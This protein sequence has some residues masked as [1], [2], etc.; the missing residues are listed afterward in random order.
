MKV[1]LPTCDKYDHLIPGFAWLFNKYWSA[2]QQVIVCGYREP[3]GLPPNFSFKSLGETET[4]PW[5]DAIRPIIAAE[6]DPYL[7]LFLDDYWLYAPIWHTV[8][9][10]LCAM[11]QSGEIQKADLSNNT[12]GLGADAYKGKTTYWVS[13]QEATYRSSLQPAIWSTKYLLK[14]LKPGRTIWQFELAG[15]GEACNDK[16]KIVQHDS[17]IFRY[18]NIYFKGGITAWQVDKLAFTDLQQ[19]WDANICRD[20]LLHANYI[21]NKE[22]GK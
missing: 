5:T 1:Y 22:K 15:I 6:T 4:L 20:I 13:K 21:Q 9:D 18:A 3:Q 16:A 12:K 8:V 11:L 19:L 17:T 7:G 2:E 14:F 10:E